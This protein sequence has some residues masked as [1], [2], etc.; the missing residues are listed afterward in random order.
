MFSF[1]P[2]KSFKKREKKKKKKFKHFEPMTKEGPLKQSEIAHFL[3]YIW[4]LFYKPFKK[5]RHNV[6]QLSADAG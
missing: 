5:H 6:K 4:F 3:P 1:H 2:P